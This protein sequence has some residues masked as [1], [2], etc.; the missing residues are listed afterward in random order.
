MYRWTREI[1]LVISLV[2]L[3]SFIS[4]FTG[5][6]LEWLLL[7]TLSLLFWQTIQINQLERRLSKGKL[8][9]KIQA[10]GIWEAIYYHLYKIQKLEKNRKKK[11]SKIIDQFRKSTNA[12][13]D[14]AIVLSENEEIEWLNIAARRVLGLNKS[15]KGRRITNL[16]RFPEFVRLLHSQDYDK[17][18]VITAPADEN[19]IL[20]IVVVPYGAGLRLMLAQD[21]TPLK[22]MERI[23]KDFVANVSHELRTPLT[24]LKGYLE[25]LQDMDENP[26]ASSRAVTQ[27]LAQTDRMQILVDD[28]LM[29]TRL[30]TKEK[31]SECVDIPALLPSIVL[32]SNFKESSEARIELKIDTDAK[33]M[34][35][36]DEL[37]S[38][39][40]NLIENALKYSPVNSIVNV[41]WYDYE[42]G[43]CLE[44]EDQGEG[45][46]KEE[47]PR[48]TERF[49][50]ADVNRN[51]KITGTG[52]GLAIVKHVLVRHDA[53]LDI[54]SELGKGSCFRC[55][56]PKKR[57]CF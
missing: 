18:L 1:Y 38:A 29:L 48:I 20:Q 54:T 7:V 34:G 22:T 32:E 47:I 19:I 53:S 43:A 25:T 49:Y 12:L 17:K 11:L 3:V 57:K 42:K 39:F 51:T 36:P 31:K 8:R 35:D 50:R 24:V 10:K 16:I 6:L 41:R 56:F 23:R 4:F 13:P 33:I 5:Y 37:R 26:S 45:I 9:K 52:L 15:D 2:F 40:S 14:A 46:A 27:M 55:L 28:L 21:I 44:V 30:E